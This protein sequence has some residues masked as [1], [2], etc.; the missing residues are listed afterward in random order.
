MCNG[1][2]LVVIGT[3][4]SHSFGSLTNGMLAQFSRQDKSDSSLDLLGCESWLLV[5][6]SNGA[7]LLHDLVEDVSHKTVHNTHASL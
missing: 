1:S 4:F 7:G 5:I 2:V 3:E 6:P